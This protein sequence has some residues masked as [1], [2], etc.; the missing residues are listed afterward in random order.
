M[1]YLVLP[2]LASLA[3]G[4]AALAQADAPP[5]SV[6][7]P[8]QTGAAPPPPP[9]LPPGDQMDDADAPPPPPGADLGGPPKGPKGPPG[10]PGMRRPPPPPPSKAA[11]FRMR[12]GPL[13]IDAKCADDE[14]TKVCVDGILML[15]DKL[16]PS[17]P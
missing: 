15:M 7:T 5:P 3:L 13:E 14:P 6:G 2:I 4:T 12:Q 9:P 10:G 8:A 11:H 16:G 1:R 17:K